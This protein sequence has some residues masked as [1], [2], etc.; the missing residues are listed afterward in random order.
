MW[1]HFLQSGQRYTPIGAWLVKREGYEL[2]FR[3]LGEGALPF[4]L[5][6]GEEYY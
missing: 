2:S 3:R 5:T 6:F 1:R 4:S